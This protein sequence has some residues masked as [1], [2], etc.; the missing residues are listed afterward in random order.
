MAWQWSAWMSR[1]VTAV[2]LGAHNPSLDGSPRA[3]D[4]DSSVSSRASAI[5]TSNAL[6]QDQASLQEPQPGP[7][8]NAFDEQRRRLRSLLYIPA[9]R[10]DQKRVRTLPPEPMARGACARAA[11][12]CD[13]LH[14]GV[15]VFRPNQPALGLAEAERVSI[16]WTQ[17]GENFYLKATEEGMQVRSTRRMVWDGEHSPLRL[18]A[19]LFVCDDP[20]A[21]DPAMLVA[22]PALL[23][24]FLRKGT[25]VGPLSFADSACEDC[26]EITLGDAYYEQDGVAV[27]RAFQCRDILWHGPVRLHYPLAFAGAACSCGKSLTADEGVGSV[28]P[29]APVEEGWARYKPFGERCVERNLKT[30][31]K[32]YALP[33]PPPGAV[34][35]ANYHGPLPLGAP[36]PMAIAPPAVQVAPPPLP[37]PLLPPLRRSLRRRRYRH[38]NLP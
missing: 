24:P 16:C 1:A 35:L 4:G 9:D 23:S 13:A 5:A 19:V 2:S 17:V 25:L 26:A 7:S 33:A 10:H 31:A 21:H 6:A 22:A 3:H 30:G 37:P 28:M 32:R 11:L 8:V 36:A 29:N 18:S 15:E 20:G 12:R 27:V 14:F 34:Y 38:R